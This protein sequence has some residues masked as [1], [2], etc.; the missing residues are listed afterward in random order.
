MSDRTSGY[1]FHA[2]GQAINPP[3][4]HKTVVWGEPLQVGDR[5]FD[6]YSG[7]LTAHHIDLAHNHHAYS[8]GRWTAYA[9]RNQR[10]SSAL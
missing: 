6:V 5:P 4:G 9:R 7:W 2:D 8:T 3:E 1:G 10:K